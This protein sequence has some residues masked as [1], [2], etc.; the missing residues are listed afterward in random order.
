HPGR[1][2]ARGKLAAL[3]WSDSG[4]AAARASLRQALLVLRRTLDLDDT[5]LIA[6][7]RD[8]VDLRADVA[9]VDALEFERLL[10]EGSDAAL[11]R[12]SALYGGE[13]L[14][15]I[16]ARAPAF[17]DWLLPRRQQLRERA[18]H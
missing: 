7:T 1:P 14:E 15:A 13:F 8:T 16:D 12:A 2:Q 11:E 10:D 18:G 4:D 3:L 9:D 6:G 5:E 17:D